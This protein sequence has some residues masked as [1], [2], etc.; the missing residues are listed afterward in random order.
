MQIKDKAIVLRTTRY[1]EHDLIVQVI[2]S[3]GAKLNL[4]A[5]SALR[6]K[7]RFGGGVLEPTHFIQVM[8]QDKSAKGGDHP[9]H[10]LNEATLVNSFPKLRSDY[11]RLEAALHAVQVITVVAH[12]GDV[13]SEAIFNLLGNTLKAAETS[14]SLDALKT[15]F[16]VKLLTLQGVLEHQ[17]EEEALLRAPISDHESLELSDERWRKLRSRTA[18]ALKSY[19]G[20]SRKLFPQS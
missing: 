5:R 15:H 20:E 14:K 16:E 7:K 19:L 3:K 18:S 13:D 9:L 11:A 2:N 4:F 17:A 1:G 8:Y 10:T 12:E 6:S